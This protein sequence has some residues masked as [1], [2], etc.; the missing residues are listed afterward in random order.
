[1][2]KVNMPEKQQYFTRWSSI[3]S[4]VKL[5]RWQRRFRCTYW[6]SNT[7]FKLGGV[8]IKISHPLIKGICK[9]TINSI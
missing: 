9:I 2:S 5:T 7:R 3:S 8:A 6:C 1:M 4:T